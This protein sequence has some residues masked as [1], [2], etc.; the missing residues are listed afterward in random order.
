M[1]PAIDLQYVVLIVAVLFGAIRGALGY[2]LMAPEGEAFNTLKFGKS[3]IRYAIVNIVG[4]NLIGLTGVEWTAVSVI[5]Y[6]IMQLS[7]DIG[8]DM[9]KVSKTSTATIPPTE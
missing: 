3:I 8:I 7:V 9:N 4:I 6:T 5:I 2:F 1:I